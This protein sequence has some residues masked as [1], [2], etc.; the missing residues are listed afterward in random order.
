MSFVDLFVNKPPTM[1]GLLSVAT[2]RCIPVPL[3]NYLNIQP[4]QVSLTESS[5]RNLA[6]F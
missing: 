2:V 6:E 5:I 4:F 3:S 1:K